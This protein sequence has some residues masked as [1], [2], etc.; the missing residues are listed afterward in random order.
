MNRI[1]NYLEKNNMKINLFIILYIGSL[2]CNAQ[3]VAFPLYEDNPIWNV[4]GSDNTLRP[5]YYDMFIQYSK[6]TTVCGKSYSE[7]PI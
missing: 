7:L 3:G 4:Y 2:T 1:V 6:D 5:G